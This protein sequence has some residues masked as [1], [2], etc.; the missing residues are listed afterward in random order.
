[1]VNSPKIIF[2]DEPTGNLDTQNSQNIIQLIQNLNQEFGQT[3]VIV[4][5][6]PDLVNIAHRVMEI[7][8]GLLT[9]R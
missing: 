2:A 1:L 6:N 5:H 8:D 9:S 7:K 3:F 4:T